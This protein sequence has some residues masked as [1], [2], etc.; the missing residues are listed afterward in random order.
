MAAQQL[1]VDVTANNLANIN[2]NGFRRSQVDFQD[3]MYIKLQEANGQASATEGA[4]Y[5]RLEWTGG[6]SSIGYREE[7]V[8][9]TFIL[10]KRHNSGWKLA[11]ISTLE[12]ERYDPYGTELT[13]LETELPPKL[14][15]P[16]LF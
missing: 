2:T 4:G 5:A 15:F 3:L 10:F 6:A 12:K 8:R 13:Y 9:Y 7:R 14:R 16:R 11:A 1:I